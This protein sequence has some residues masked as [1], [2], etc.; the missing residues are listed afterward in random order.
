MSRQVFRVYLASGWF[1]EKEEDIRSSLE[2]YLSKRPDVKLYSPKRDGVMLNADQKNNKEVLKSVFRDNVSHID[3]SDYVVANIWS[4]H[5]YNDPGT[6]YEIG[7]ALAHHIPVIGYT[8]TMINVEDRFKGITSA[9][10]AIATDLSALDKAID[11]YKLGVSEKNLSILYVGNGNLDTD[12][13]LLS[14]LLDSGAL[15]KCVNNE[16]REIY[17]DI[18]SIF[19]KVDLVIAVIDDRK[20]IVSWT[21]GQAFARNIPIATYSDQ[22]YGIN[23]MLLCSLLT[24]IRGEDEMKEFLEQIKNGLDT[25]PEFDI[26]QI[27]SM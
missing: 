26:S 5:W 20:T 9:F 27:E 16:H 4:E 21:M 23:V 24:H 13:K 10:F 8:P 6:M 15:V 12:D 1:S 14:M 2:D 19:D 18:E 22:G 7:Y 3:G 11:Q 17:R 25:V